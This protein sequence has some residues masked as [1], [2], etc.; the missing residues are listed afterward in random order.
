MIILLAMK[1]IKLQ[2]KSDLLS[3]NKTL[4]NNCDHGYIKEDWENVLHLLKVKPVIY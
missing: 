2:D 1:Y 3:L 4:A